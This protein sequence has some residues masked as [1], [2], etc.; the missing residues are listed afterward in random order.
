MFFSFRSRFSCS[1]SPFHSPLHSLEG[2]QVECSTRNKLMP[3]LA[4]SCSHGL[5]VWSPLR[6]CLCFCRR[7]PKP[8]ILPGQ[9]LSQVTQ[10]QKKRVFSQCPLMGD[11]FTYV[12]D[13][14]LYLSLIWL[15]SYLWINQHIWYPKVSICPIN[16]SQFATIFPTNTIAE[17]SS[18]H[19]R[20]DIWHTLV[21][22]TLH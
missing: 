7:H 6:G 22:R 8:T 15:I 11:F 9:S 1:A 18:G 16:N 3:N 21:R 4:Q 14:E 19:F 2:E 17:S 13:A 12:V 10:S 20:A 5:A